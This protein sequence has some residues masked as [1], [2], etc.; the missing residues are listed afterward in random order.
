MDDG[1]TAEGTHAV[2]GVFGIILEKTNQ[3]TSRV[4]VHHGI[5]SS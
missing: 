3:A 2:L 5:A 1:R 4:L